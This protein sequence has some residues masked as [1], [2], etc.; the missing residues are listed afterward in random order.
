[1]NEFTCHGLRVAYDDTGSA[2]PMTPTEDRRA[3]PALLLLH[4]W[5]NGRAT[6][7][8]LGRALARSFRTIALDQPGHGD[9]EP[10]PPGRARGLLSVPGQ[11]ATAAALLDHLGIERA[12]LVGHSSGGAVAVDL[13][14]RRPGLARAVVALDG[15]ILLVPALLASGPTLL[16]ALQS[17]HWRGAMTEQIRRGY[18]SSDDPGL[19]ATQLEQ[20]SR[21]SRDDFAAL[22]ET[23]GCWDDEGALRAV[24]DHGIPMLYVDASSMVRLADM[25]ALVPQ[26]RV[27]EI[28]GLGHMQLIGHTDLALEAMSDF[29]ADIE[30]EPQPG[31]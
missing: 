17:P 18:L 8:P 4:G 25:A 29:F 5:G 24:A 30:P 11:A 16:A 2:P 23:I 10:P 26:L 3:A 19:M 1:M 28:I 12:I 14:A 7:R 21:I 20:L 22:P 9:S 13:A 6:M 27:E 15:T 31:P